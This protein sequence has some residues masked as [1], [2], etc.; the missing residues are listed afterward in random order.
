MIPYPNS[1]NSGGRLAYLTHVGCKESSV[2]HGHVFFDSDWKCTYLHDR[3]GQPSDRC[4]SYW[5]LGCL[6]RDGTQRKFEDYQIDS[7]QC[8]VTIICVQTIH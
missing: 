2:S 4:T 5:G 8:T 1:T 7:V 6:M 3:T